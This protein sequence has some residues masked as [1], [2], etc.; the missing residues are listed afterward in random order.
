MEIIIFVLF[1]IIIYINMHFLIDNNH[2]III[3]VSAKCGCSTIRTFFI[4]LSNEEK[5]K[6]ESKGNIFCSYEALPENYLEYK[7]FIIIRNP[8]KRIISGFFNKYAN[9]DDKY[10]Y[11]YNN[12]FNNSGLKLNFKNFVDILEKEKLGKYIEIHHFTPQLS[13]KWDDKLLKHPDITFYDI[14]NINYDEI[15]KH[16]NNNIN[17]INNIKIITK[18]NLKKNNIINAHLIEIIKLKQLSPDYKCLYTK[19]IKEKVYNYYKKDFELFK[20]LGFNYDI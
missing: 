4:S 3:G 14:S 2:K 5:K 8:Y 1:K 7:I 13:E 18:N 20:L 19:E 6:F 12:K 17:N 10:L 9:D 16:F 15:K 11:M